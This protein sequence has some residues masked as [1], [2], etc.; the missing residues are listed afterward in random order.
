M[1]KIK[2]SLIIIAIVFIIRSLW[3]LIVH[4]NA[5]EDFMTTI[6]ISLLLGLL[7]MLG[8]TLTKWY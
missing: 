2:S 8:G 7:S 3:Q 4:G 5:F 1:P 6:L